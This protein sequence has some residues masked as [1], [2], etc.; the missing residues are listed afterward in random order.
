MLVP[1]PPEK[2]IAALN[3]SE[4]SVVDSSRNRG[5]RPRGKP[6]TGGRKAGTPNKTTGAV[7]EMI[8]GALEGVGGMG[9]L[10][11]QANENPASFMTLLGKV[12]PL[13]V[14]GDGG[15][16]V[17]IASKIELVALK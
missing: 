7:K 5:G 2:H 4:E 6:K 17:E 13:Q 1:S 8:L 15:G 9:Y 16:P 11:R 12:L 10:Q 14:T 3:M